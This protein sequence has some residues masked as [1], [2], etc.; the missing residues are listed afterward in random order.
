MKYTILFPFERLPYFTIEGFKQ[1]ADDQLADDSHARTALYR[2]VK[3]GHLITLKKGVYMHRRFFE[4]HHQD[5][6]FLP[7]VSAI[8]LSQSYLSLEYVLQQHG[9]L[10]EI[11]YPLTAITTKNTRTII[12]SLG[13]FVYHH[14]QADLYQG[15]QIT[16]AY[17]VYFAQAT[18]AKALFDYL[19][20]RPLQGDLAPQHYNLAEELRLNLDEFSL[21]ERE[22]FTSYIQIIGEDKRG[23]N[24]MH[25]ILENLEYHVWLP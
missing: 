11:T 24:K 15:F 2:W 9:I 20:L 4:Q 21:D 8:F 16:E 14:I 23:N 13:T 17:G 6:A 12:N 3:A 1:I 18:A 10:T 22:E 25:R 19:Y 5:S 7:L